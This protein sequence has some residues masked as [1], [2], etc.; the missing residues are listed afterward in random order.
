METI[1]TITTA[2]IILRVVIPATQKAKYIT[3]YT[4]AVDNY[5]KAKVI[6]EEFCKANPHLE[7]SSLSLRFLQ[8]I[9]A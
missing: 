7:S 3:L 1:I 5:E 8:K 4:T 9:W 2:S 6:H